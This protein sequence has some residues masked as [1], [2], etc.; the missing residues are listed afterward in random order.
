MTLRLRSPLNPIL[1]ALVAVAA[2]VAAQESAPPQ[3]TPPVGGDT[4]SSPQAP[5]SDPLDYRLQLDWHP[6]GTVVPK[7]KLTFRNYIP[8]R[9]IGF[10]ADRYDLLG[11]TYGLG[12]GWEGTV[13]ITGAERLG[14]GGYA[15]FFGA[16]LQKQLISETRSRPAVSL[17][18]YGMTGPHDHHGGSVYLAATKRVWG[19][20]P[21][22]TALFLH[23]G[24]KLELYDS[25]D[26]GNGT[27]IR[28]YVGATL[29]LTRRV[30]LNGDFSPSQPWERAN[31]YAVRGTYRVYKRLGITGG[32]RNNGY[33]TLPFIG[34]NF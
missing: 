9:P 15:L 5:L 21:R 4:A 6:V 12:G 31:L 3:G 13:G 8:M 16:G 32:I 28:P 10:R 29:A 7:G 24:G 11:P 33:R 26:Y 25:D 14:P 20:G 17:G 34:V 2:P 19:P 1:A 23:G 30:T 27:G 22:G 18:G